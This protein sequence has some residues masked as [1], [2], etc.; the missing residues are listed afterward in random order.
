MGL[1]ARSFFLAI[2]VKTT[3]IGRMETNE[4]VFANTANIYLRR[5]GCDQDGEAMTTHS[6]LLL[7]VI[8]ANVPYMLKIV[9]PDDDEAHAGD[10][11]AFYGGRG[12]VRLVER[13]GPVQLLE[14]VISDAAEESLKKMAVRGRDDEATQIICD[15]IE[16]LHE[17]AA[18]TKQVPANLKP[19]R[20]RTQE[21]KELLSEGRVQEED[22]PLIL[23]ACALTDEFIVQAQDPA[24]ILHGDIHHY[25]VLHSAERGWLAI[26]PKGYI[27]PRA[28]EYAPALCNP[29]LHTNIVADPTRM[30]RRAAIM[31]EHSGLEKDE[32]LRFAFVHACQVAAWCLSTPDQRYWLA[33]ARTAAGLMS[34]AS[35]PQKTSLQSPRY[36]KN[37]PAAPLA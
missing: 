36:P 28:Y 19:F 33:C 13:D 21:M 32:L 22:K 27:G 18:D 10:M 4:S 37:G 5:W 15:V 11:L 24:T 7:P 17:T 30:D 6:S 14:R 25:N 31:A 26:D 3:T 1:S 23:S 20:E 16:R 9:R 2:S 35:R 29:T 34:D 8:R 12:A